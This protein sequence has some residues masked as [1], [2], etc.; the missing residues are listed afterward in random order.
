VEADRTFLDGPL[1]V[2][3]FGELPFTSI[4]DFESNIDTFTARVDLRMGRAN[5]LTAG[6]EVERESYGDFSSDESPNP[7]SASLDITERSQAFFAQNQTRLFDDRLQLSLAFRLQNFDLSSPLFRGGAPR[8][9]GLTF[10]SPPRAYTGDG[11]VAYFFKSTN[12]K[13]RAHVGNGYRSPSLFERF[14]ASFF[15]GDFTAFGD[16]RL[17]PERSI[18]VDGGIDQTMLRGRV[19]LSAT[20]FYTRLQNIILF[21]STP[22]DD[23]FN[24]PFGGYRNI[25]GGMAR[26]VELS[27]QISPARST[28]LFASYTYTNADQRTPDAAG[29]L[30][31]PATS[32]H[33]FTMVATQ[34]IGRRFDLTFDLSGISDYSPS[35]PSPSFN[36]LYVFDGYVKADLGA[37]YTLPMNDRHSLR[38]YGKVENVLD[39]TYFE[40]GFRAPGATFTGGMSYR[41]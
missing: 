36:T 32:A 40:S 5:L 11:S 24:R 31:V 30:T 18:S 8:Y 41:F 19:R 27:A 23:P 26:G 34:R 9:A 15:F 10:D 21:G 22:P 39:R 20:Y 6:Y 25:E 28:D 33:I 12:T 37:G 16:P 3:A 13:L 2:G 14:G 1:G 4:S 29:N 38:F 7:P 17:K 35:F